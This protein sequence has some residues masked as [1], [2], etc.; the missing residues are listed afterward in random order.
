LFIFL[1]DNSFSNSCCNNHYNTVVLLLTVV[2]VVGDIVVEQFV[3][4]LHLLLV[5]ADKQVDLTPF[6]LLV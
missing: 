3:D 2:V 6:V 5:A 1:V 4:E